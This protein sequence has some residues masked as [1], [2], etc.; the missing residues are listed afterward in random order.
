LVQQ[1]DVICSTI[2]R[3]PCAPIFA[4]LWP[5]GAE[6]TALGLTEDGSI[7]LRRCDHRSE[8]V[9]LFVQPPDLLP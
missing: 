4:A 6:P 7:E 8:M 2:W 9:I 1:Q 3:F 5:Q